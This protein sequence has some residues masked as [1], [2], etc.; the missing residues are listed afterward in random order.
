MSVISNL[1]NVQ[2][3]IRQ[4]EVRSGRSLGSVKLLVV[5]KNASENQIRE[6][7]EAGVREYGENKVQELLKKRDVFPG[8]HW[9]MIGHLQTN[10]VKQIA[11][12]VV[13]IHSLDRWSLAE[14]LNKAALNRNMMFNVL[15]QVNVSGEKTKHGLDPQETKDFVAD[16]S[17]LDGIK[18]KGLMTMAP[19]TENPED[20]RWVFRG[21]RDMQRKLVNTWSELQLL[22]MGMSNDFEV[23]VEEGADIVR[24]GSSIFKYEEGI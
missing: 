2:E 24:I 4:A 20:V 9:H 10:K 8:V 7:Y 19:F 3:R 15:V 13:L 21:L 6:I 18:I 17:K 11:G 14:T 22:S 23:A 16:V 12:K 5:I 1:R